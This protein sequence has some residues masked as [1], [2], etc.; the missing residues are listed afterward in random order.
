MTDMIVDG[1]S[2]FARS[3]YAAQKNIS[4]DPAE[5]IS[6]M[7][8]T[9]ILL[10][11]PTSFSKLGVPFDRTLFAWDGKQNPLK[12]REEKPPEYHETKAIV[13][14]T[15]EFIFGTVNFQHPEFEGDDVVAT[16]VFNTQP[17]DI[18]YIVSADKD[19]QQLQG[20][21]SHYY[22]LNTKA[23]LTR[24]FINSKWHVRR[25][26]HLALALAIIGDPVDCIRGVVGYGPVKCRQMFE[27][28][29]AE[30]NFTKAMNALAEQMPKAKL[31][32]FYESLNRTLLQTDVP[33][34][35]LPAPLRLIDPAEVRRTGIPNVY[36]LYTEMFDAYEAKNSRAE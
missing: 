5:A 35:P 29:T 15:L 1:N 32:E 22:C 28:I 30:M 2:L 17:R 10:L 14:D 8:R 23:L 4:T 36:K 9:I 7:L 25:P 6:L 18:V 33:G 20:P 11:S 12:N 26:S 16:A 34:V 24:Q 13:Q 27:A 19:L 3:W 31:E 21:R